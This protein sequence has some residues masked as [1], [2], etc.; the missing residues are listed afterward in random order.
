MDSEPDGEPKR[1]GTNPG[2]AQIQKTNELFRRGEQR[3]DV[4]RLAEFPGKGAQ[5]VED[6][7]RNS[8]RRYRNVNRRV[9]LI[10]APSQSEQYKGIA[11]G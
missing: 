7:R 6:C 8:E 4:E 5:K 9:V 3:S 11:R 1:R 2:E 10:K